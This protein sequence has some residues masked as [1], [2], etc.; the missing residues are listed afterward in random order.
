[1]KFGYARISTDNQTTD[2]QIDAL[3]AYGVDEI[4]EEKITGIIKNRPQ[5]D[6]L[7]NKLRKDDTLVIYDLKR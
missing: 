7:L 2:R 6:L 1:M 3:K 5:L 4:Y